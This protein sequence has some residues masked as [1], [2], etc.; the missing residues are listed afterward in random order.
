MSSCCLTPRRL[1]QDLHGGFGVH[2]WGKGRESRYR[3]VRRLIGHGGS[4][5]NLLSNRRFCGGRTRTLPVSRIQA[6]LIIA[7]CVPLGADR[8]QQLGV[9]GEH[10]HKRRVFWDHV[11]SGNQRGAIFLVSSQFGWSQFRWSSSAGPGS[12]VTQF[13]LP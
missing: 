5:E 6:Y 10:V 1:A 13:G 11:K 4:G 8:M 2:T 9:Q 3:C 12:A 7:V